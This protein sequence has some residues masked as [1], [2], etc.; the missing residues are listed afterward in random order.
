MSLLRKIMCRI[1]L[2]FGRIQHERDANGIWWLGLRCRHCG[3]LKDPIKSMYQE[4]K[5]SRP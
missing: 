2:C 4:S 3:K 1:G 5:R